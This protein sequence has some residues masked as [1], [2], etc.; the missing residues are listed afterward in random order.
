MGGGGALQELAAVRGGSHVDTLVPLEELLEGSQVVGRERSA[1]PDTGQA[2]IDD[3]QRLNVV[4][5]ELR[6]E[7]GER[8]IAEYQA[9]LGPGAHALERRS[10]TDQDAAHRTHSR[11]LADVKIDPTRRRTTRPSS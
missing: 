4:A 5:I 7:V 3:A 8:L 6:D 10:R 1:H 2:R 11:A 9:S